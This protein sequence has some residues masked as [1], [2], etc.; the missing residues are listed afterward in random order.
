MPSKLPKGKMMDRD[1]FFNIFNTL[2][3]E[4]VKALVSTANN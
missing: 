1:Y 4:E 3:P 2:Y